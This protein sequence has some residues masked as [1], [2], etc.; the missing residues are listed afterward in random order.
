MAAQEEYERIISALGLRTQ[1]ELAELLDVRQSSIS[2]ALKRNDPDGVP[3]GWKLRLLE[4]AGLRPEWIRTGEGPR[5]MVSSDDGVN[6]A[7]NYGRIRPA[8]E[9]LLAD[10]GRRVPGCAVTFTF[11]RNQEEVPHDQDA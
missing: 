6:T 3:A 5:Y 1:V 10:I 4:A 7:P 9:E 11:D 8:L 2:D